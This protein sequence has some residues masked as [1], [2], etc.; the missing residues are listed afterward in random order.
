MAR[1]RCHGICLAGALTSFSLAHV[2]ITLRVPDITILGT[3]YQDGPAQGL[4]KLDLHALSTWYRLS[5]VHE[6]QSAHGK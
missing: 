6:D 4:D 3:D 1:S 5:R 2:G